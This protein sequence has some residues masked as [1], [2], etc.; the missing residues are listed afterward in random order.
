MYFHFYTDHFSAVVNPCNTGGWWVLSCHQPRDDIRVPFQEASGSP[1]PCAWAVWKI[2]GRENNSKWMGNTWELMCICFGQ[3]IPIIVCFPQPYNLV[4][5]AH[6]SCWNEAIL[7]CLLHLLIFWS[8][9]ANNTFLSQ[10]ADCVES[11]VLRVKESW[12]HNRYLLLPWKE[13]WLHNST[14]PVSMSS[15]GAPENS[16]ERDIW[17]GVFGV[18][19]GSGCIP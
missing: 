9:V 1:K 12:L 8:L 11:R 13:P 17:W 14:L 2:P 18:A 5:D 10:D 6:C 7:S 4:S 15:A 3:D 16:N 19:S